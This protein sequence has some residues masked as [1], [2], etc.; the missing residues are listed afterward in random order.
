MVLD[1][2]SFGAEGDAPNLTQPLVLSCGGIYVPHQRLAHDPQ[3][4]KSWRQIVNLPGP[5]LSA[6]IFG[7]TAAKHRNLQEIQRKE[8][9]N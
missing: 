2:L 9:L 4:M 1:E 3:D 8:F 5:E 6:K 7:F